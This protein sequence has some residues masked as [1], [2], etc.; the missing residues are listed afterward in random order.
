[1]YDKAK[2]ERGARIII[3]AFCVFI[4]IVV[5]AIAWMIDDLIGGSS[6]KEYSDLEREN[7]RWSHEA[8]DYIHSGK[9]A[10]DMG[11]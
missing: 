7:L 4:V 1:M 2:D 9:A 5:G 11:Y 3:G 8:Y 10:K 6:S